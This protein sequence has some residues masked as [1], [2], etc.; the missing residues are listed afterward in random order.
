MRLYADGTPEPAGFS[1]DNVSTFISTAKEAKWLTSHIKALD[2]PG[3]KITEKEAAT[4]LKSLVEAGVIAYAKDNLFKVDFASAELAANFLFI[5]NIVHFKA[6]SEEDN[7]IKVVECA[8]LQAGVHD[9]I[10]INVSAK[11]IDISAVSSYNMIE[12]I[13]LMM[14][15]P[16]SF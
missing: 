6:G 3:M 4:G 12:N 10:S 7:K 8:Y 16:P 1:A 14:T 13:R 5:E 9:I 15:N 2:I 11:G